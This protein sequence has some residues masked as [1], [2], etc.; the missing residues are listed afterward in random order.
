V[1][2]REAG[3]PGLS[4]FGILTRKVAS[5]S[6][7]PLRI[8]VDPLPLRLQASVQHWQTEFVVAS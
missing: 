7:S 8:P 2:R 5:R 4:D 6:W 3:L 1:D